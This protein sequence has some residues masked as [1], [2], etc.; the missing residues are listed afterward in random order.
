MGEGRSALT[1]NKT[2]VFSV[3]NNFY[4]Y[5]IVLTLSQFYLV[6]TLQFLKI[7]LGFNY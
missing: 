6:V 3:N 2:I 5:V 4:A 7:S 1:Y